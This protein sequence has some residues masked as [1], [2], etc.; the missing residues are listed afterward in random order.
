LRNDVITLVSELA[1]RGVFDDP[2]PASNTIPCEVR[3][4][5]RS[6]AYQARAAGLNPSIVFRIR[7]AEDYNDETTV[8]YNDKRYRVVRTYQDDFWLELICEKAT[9]NMEAD[10]E[11]N[12]RSS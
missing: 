6:E 5:T 3:S 9:Y 4:V 10:D 2:V 12:Q 8:I 11:E 7:I 1:P